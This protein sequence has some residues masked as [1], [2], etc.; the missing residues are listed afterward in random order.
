DHP[1]LDITASDPGALAAHCNER[2]DVTV[3]KVDRGVVRVRL[4][5]IDAAM[6]NA[7]LVTS[8]FEVSA[9][10]PATRSLEDLFLEV[11]A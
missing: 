5:D 11:T 7:A 2:S 10:V 1:L 8:G 6:F 9:F 4:D 3:V